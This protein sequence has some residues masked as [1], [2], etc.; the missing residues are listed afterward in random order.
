MDSGIGPQLHWDQQHGSVLH[1]LTPAG[2]YE[3]VS[4]TWDT[5]VSER[6][7]AVVVD[8]RQ[9]LLTPLRLGLVPPP[10]CAA[11]VAL[12]EVRHWGSCWLTV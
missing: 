4:V 10:M 2:R 3:T 8:G 1:M 5:C 9:L 11:R 12:P 7:T 6:G